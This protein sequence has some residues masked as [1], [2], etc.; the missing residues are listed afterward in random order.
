[1]APANNGFVR[2]LYQVGP[3]QLFVSSGAGLWAGFAVRLGV[4]SSID[5]LV[6]RSPPQPP[7]PEPRAEGC[8]QGDGPPRPGRCSTPLTG[9]VQQPRCPPHRRAVDGQRRLHALQAFQRRTRR[10]R[11]HSTETLCLSHLVAVGMRWR[12]FLTR[13]AAS[14]LKSQG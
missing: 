6:L 4:P 3:M 13:M 8:Y 2:G 9:R 1:V 5:L 11:E 14:T 12:H 7:S 10:T